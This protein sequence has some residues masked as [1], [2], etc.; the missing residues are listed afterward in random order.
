[1]TAEAV[2]VERRWRLL[3][4]PYAERDGRGPETAPVFEIAPADGRLVISAIHAVRH[5]RR[6]RGWKEQDFSTG[7]L[8]L[9]LAEA[10]G[11]SVATC[12]RSTAEV[13]DANR[14]RHHPIKLELAHCG[15]P[16]A[17]GALLDLHGMADA[18]DRPDI[19]LGYG[20]E[21]DWT[22]ELAR[23]I[24][25]AAA[26]HVV[27]VGRG[28]AIGL[29][30]TGRG[31]MTQWAQSQGAGALQLELAARV[32]QRASVDGRRR[33]VDTLLDAMRTITGAVPPTAPAE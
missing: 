25:E 24:E 21:D 30:A 11:W 20:V 28:D 32:R 17:G 1:V 2:A 26:R 27:T 3:N 33:L 29:G 19:A 15:L 8:A 18:T 4:E 22:S 9:A 31:T 10:T 5:F 14:N 12:T 16:S 7:G 13:E 6:G 23:H